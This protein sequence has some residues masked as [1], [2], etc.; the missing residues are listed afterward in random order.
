MFEQMRIECDGPSTLNADVPDWNK[1]TG[2]TPVEFLTATYRNPFQPMQHRIS[3]AKA[4]MDYTHQKLPSKVEVKS[5]NATTLSVDSSA[6]K[7]LSDK[8]L[9]TLMS[10]LE[11]AAS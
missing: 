8:E 6:M 1:A 5:D 2:W 9:S 7:K 3:A 11:K 4:A 10:L